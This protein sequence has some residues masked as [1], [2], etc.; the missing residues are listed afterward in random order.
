MRTDPLPGS[1][2]TGNVLDG[3]PSEYCIR[4][5]EAGVVRGEVESTLACGKDVAVRS[6]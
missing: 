4:A 6:E 1:Y 2:A 3:G 5:S